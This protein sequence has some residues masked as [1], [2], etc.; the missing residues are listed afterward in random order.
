MNKLQTAHGYSDISE[1]ARLIRTASSLT[2]TKNPILLA[3][4]PIQKF[5]ITLRVRNA[6]T[7]ETGF[8]G[9]VTTPLAPPAEIFGANFEK[10][11]N[12]FVY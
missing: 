5:L 6:E 4:I 11:Y 9:F 12:T 2:P 10:I 7:D 1:P 3:S 8:G